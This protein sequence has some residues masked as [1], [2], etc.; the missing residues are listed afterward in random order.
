MSYKIN[1]EKLTNITPNHQDTWLVPNG[2]LTFDINIYIV[3]C[4]QYKDDYDL[5][6]YIYN[7]YM[8]KNLLSS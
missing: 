6:G 8:V 4:R 1:H 2:G 7:K 5:F 3:L